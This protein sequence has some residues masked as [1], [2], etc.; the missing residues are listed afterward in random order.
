MAQMKYYYELTISSSPHVHSP[1]TTQ[2]I[3]RDVLIALAPALIG[4]VYFFGFRALTVTMVSAL[5]AFLFEKL[6][7]NLSSCRLAA[8]L[9][10]KLSCCP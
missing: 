10:K 4:S 1:V 2:T 9:L 5:A 3:M 6:F 7:C 8:K